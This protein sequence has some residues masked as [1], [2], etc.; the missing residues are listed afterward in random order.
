MRVAFDTSVTE[1]DPGGISRYVQEL[2]AALERDAHG[3][4]L[5][6]VSM[7]E[8]WPATK[9]LERH[10]KVLV[11]DQL[12]VARGMVSTARRLE[13]DLIHGSAFKVAAVAEPAASVTIHDDTPWDSPPT[14][15]LYNRLNLRRTLERAAPVVRGA[16]VSSEATAS[17][18]LRHLPALAGRT[19]VTPFGINHAAFRPVPEHLVERA[20]ARYGIL[21]RPYV[22]MVGPYGPRKNYPRMMEAL[23]RMHDQP[24]GLLVVVAGR[25]A[26]VGRS[27]LP[28]IQ[29]GFVGDEDLAALYAGAEFLF[30]ASLSEGFGFPVLEAMACGCPVLTARGT[31]LEELA[32]GAAALVDPTDVNAMT[33][34]CE[35]MIADRGLRQG[36]AAAGLKRA[37]L[38]DW[39]Q[40]AAATAQAWQ[41]MTSDSSTAVAPRTEP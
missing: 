12:W 13:A 5:V 1:T 18:I 9:R 29:T 22:L 27:S 39:D 11:H 28:V 14:A 30:Y 25:A 8:E 37:G 4:E 16:L 20:R 32:G 21:G 35:S 7:F 38:F 19:Y 17:A 34:A 33:A 36:L 26:G 15:S 24:Q 6:R 41:S 10:L 23:S 3:I 31:V 2:L 40:T